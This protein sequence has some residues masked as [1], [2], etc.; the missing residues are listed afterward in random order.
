MED[1]E[2]L[3]GKDTEMPPLVNSSG[4]KISLTYLNVVLRMMGDG[5]CVLHSVNIIYI[6]EMWGCGCIKKDLLHT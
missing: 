6:A 2:A 5:V 4:N 1:E 3:A